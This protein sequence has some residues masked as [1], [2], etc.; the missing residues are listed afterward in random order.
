MLKYLC[1]QAGTVDFFFFFFLILVPHL[2]RMEVL[3]LGVKSE[4]Q[5]LAYAAAT[6][7]RD[8][9][10]TCDLHH[11]LRQR[12]IFNPLSEVRDR[13]LMDISWVLNLLN[14]NGNC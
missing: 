3:R 13:T 10:C 4:L 8:P 7:A 14:Y 5:L 11:S 12:Q 2:W 1:Q 6:A 9:S